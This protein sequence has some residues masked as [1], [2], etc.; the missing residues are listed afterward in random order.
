MIV[1]AEGAGKKEDIGFIKSN[2]KTFEEMYTEL[3]HTFETVF[4]KCNLSIDTASDADGLVKE[5]LKEFKEAVL[6]FDFASA[7]ALLKKAR[8]A[9]DAENYT[10]LLDQLEIYVDEIDVDK[11]LSLEL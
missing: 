6:N 9:K 7:A 5:I 10:E 8:M 11:I 4:Q 3:L 1:L 2:L